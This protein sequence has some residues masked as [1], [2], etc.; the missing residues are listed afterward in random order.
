MPEINAHRPG[1]PSWVDVVSP[2]LEASRNFYTGLFGWTAHVSPDPATGG[3]TV[4]HL[5]GLP[6]AGLS[7]LFGEGQAPAW[8]TYISVDD[9]RAAVKR[10]V[11]AGATVILEPTDVVDAGRMA[12]LSSPLGAQFSLWEAGA[13]PGARVVN[14]PG[15]L[16]W[17]E[18][19]SRDVETEKTFYGK[20]F[21]W[22]SETRPSSGSGYTT[23]KLD[24]HSVAGMVHMDEEWP[25]EIPDDWMVYFAVDDCDD[26]AA[27]AAR[28]GGSVS[29]PPREMAGVGRFAV[30]NDRHGAVFSVITMPQ[31]RL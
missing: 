21:G 20:V 22:E 9:A 2:D 30:L 19:A 13:L 7:P 25:P 31:R 18:L 29:I 24:G 11:K 14:E 10:A 17:N 1:T 28:L 3:Y 5:R 23:W 12:I 6:V 27:R 16:C 15:A 26:A 8:S 4:F